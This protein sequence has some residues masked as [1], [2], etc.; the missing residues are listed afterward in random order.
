MRICDILDY[1]ED[2]SN[3]EGFVFTLFDPMPSPCSYMITCTHP[4]SVNEVGYLIHLLGL[5]FHLS[6]VDFISI[7]SKFKSLHHLGADYNSQEL[8]H[9]WISIVLHGPSFH[10]VVDL[11]LGEQISL[12]P[13]KNIPPHINIYFGATST[14]FFFLSCPNLREDFPPVVLPLSSSFWT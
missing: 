6:G 1:L 10:H 11:D 9:H 7:G 3:L 13:K 5:F 8:S 12:L 14:T 4:L 2:R